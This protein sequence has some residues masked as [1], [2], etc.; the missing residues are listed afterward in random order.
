MNVVS[1]VGIIA[2]NKLVM[3]GYGFVFGKLEQICRHQLHLPAIFHAVGRAKPGN[4][5]LLTVIDTH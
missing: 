5:H 3:S 2:V 4:H 1:S